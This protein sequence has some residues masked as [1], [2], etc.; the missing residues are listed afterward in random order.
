MNSI[1][2]LCAGDPY[3]ALAKADD[4][5]KKRTNEMFCNAVAKLGT[6]LDDSEWVLVLDGSQATTCMHLTSSSVPLRKILVP[7]V[8]T[9]SVASLRNKGVTNAFCCDVQQ[10]LEQVPLTRSDFCLVMP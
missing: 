10:V 3:D 2:I 6:S 1:F 7:N 4:P 5:Q 8:Y 9:S